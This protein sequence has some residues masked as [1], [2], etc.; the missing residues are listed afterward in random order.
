M[1]Q[2]EIK[3][4]I[5]VTP[6]IVCFAEFTV[7]AAETGEEE[8]VS[9]DDFYAVSN[10]SKGNVWVSYS[11]GD[12]DMPYDGFMVAE[13]VE[14]VREIV[15]VARRMQMEAFDKYKNIEL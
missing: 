8:T 15:K 7:H 1:T 10:D 2:E 14:E 9:L 11:T 5:S 3:K 12:D 4:R 6:T 13:T